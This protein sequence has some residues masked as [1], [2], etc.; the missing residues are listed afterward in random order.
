[1][2]SANTAYQITI[3]Y[4][5]DINVTCHII[6]IYV[7]TYIGCKTDDAHFNVLPIL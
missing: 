7:Y 5:R 6:D 3:L 1:M 2:T 4:V